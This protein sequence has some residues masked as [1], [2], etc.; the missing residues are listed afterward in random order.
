[1]KH[2]KIFKLDDIDTESKY[3]LESMDIT[4]GGVLI[5]RNNGSSIDFLLIN[6]KNMIEDFGG[7]ID[8]SDEDIYDT[9]AREAYEESNGLLHK[10]TI[11]NRLLN[12]PFVYT[13][14]S[15]YILFII[16]ATKRESNLTSE[17][18]GDTEFHDNIKRYVKW[19]SY[20]KFMTQS[21]ISK[22]NYRLKN[23]KLFIL[24]DGIR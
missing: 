3:G 23:R 8:E 12:A 21:I 20:K 10:K 11:R 2:K 15:K 22:L 6:S 19:I 16:K 7:G 18:F 14:K 17:E 5:Y 24:L 13:P 1:M 4:A 9:V